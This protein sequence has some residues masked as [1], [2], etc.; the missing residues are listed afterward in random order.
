[1]R[2]LF[3]ENTGPVNIESVINHQNT[4]MESLG[5]YNTDNTDAMMIGYPANSITPAINVPVIADSNFNQLKKCTVNSK[6][7]AG[8]NAA[9]QDA[10]L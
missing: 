6:I 9:M 7:L 4:V 5:N 10:P 3:N 1:M 2:S 8:I